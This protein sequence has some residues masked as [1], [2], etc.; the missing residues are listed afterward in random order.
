MRKIKSIFFSLQIIFILQ[1]IKNYTFHLLYLKKGLRH[2]NPNLKLR[3]NHINTK[4]QRLL[5][6]F[7]SMNYLK[8]KKQL[9]F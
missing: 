4:L 2:M 3:K 5:E 7:D 8:Q 6:T 9:F 1:I